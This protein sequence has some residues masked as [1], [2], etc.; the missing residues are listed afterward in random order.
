MRTVFFWGL[1][2]VVQAL[3]DPLV[4]PIA[5]HLKSEAVDKALKEAEAIAAK[6]PPSSENGAIASYNLAT[7]SYL[8]LQNDSNFLKAIE[9]V[10]PLIMSLF[11]ADSEVAMDL[12][13]KQLLV[14]SLGVP[15]NSKAVKME[16]FDLIEK[17]F[18]RGKEGVLRS[19]VEFSIWNGQGQRAHRVVRHDGL[20]L[21]IPSIKLKG[22]REVSCASLMRVFPANCNPQSCP[23]VELTTA[24]RPCSGNTFVKVYSVE[25]PVLEALLG[26]VRGEAVL[27]GKEGQTA[28]HAN[29]VRPK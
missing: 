13:A 24:F 12:L 17:T 23:T 14:A 7:L 19:F 11:K 9:K 8:V 1:F 18:G 15:S 27:I 6:F 26:P 2:W 20:Y 5:E 4:A 21:E 10:Q 3:G 29:R 28:G 22:A 25:S 16:S